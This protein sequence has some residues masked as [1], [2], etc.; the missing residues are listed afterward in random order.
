MTRHLVRTV[1]RGFVVYC[2][3]TAVV[4]RVCPKGERSSLFF[5]GK[6][7]FRLNCEFTNFLALGQENVSG[8]KICVGDIKKEHW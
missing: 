2:I 1:V 7:L 6:H 3:K 4:L 5:N 8:V